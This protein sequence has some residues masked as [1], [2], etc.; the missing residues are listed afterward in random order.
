MRRARQLAGVIAL[1]AASACAHARPAPPAPDVA[2]PDPPAA[3]RVR[4]A[5][6][7]PDP[8]APPPRRSWLRAALDLVAGVGEKERRRESALE[9]PFGVAALADGALAIADP[10][11]ASV[12]RVSA[13]GEVSRIECSGRD[14]VAPM[15][16]APGPD[17]ALWIA[18][19][20]AAELVRVAADGRC[21]AIG[22]GLLERP[23]GLVVEAERVV[24]VDPPRHELVVLSTAGALVARFGTLGDGDGQLHFP[25]ALARAADGTLLVIDALNFRIARF[26]PAGEWLGAFGSAGQSGGALARPKGI[27]VDAAGR[28]YVSDAQ[29]DLVLVYSPAGEF[30]CALAASGTDPG[31]LTMPA[32][33]AIAGGRLYVADSLNHR[34][35][36]FEI[37]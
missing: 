13:R 21:T 7:F 35:Q 1:V 2:W 4:L 5:T 17:G 34:V 25:S 8:S 24:V 11:G 29:R 10:D 20:G 28:I 19:A 9:R 14:W 23:T 26:S 16:A 32:G 27:A 37:L 3:P 31:R 30:D 22:G 33:I 18:D 36:A 6:I 15:S 12:V